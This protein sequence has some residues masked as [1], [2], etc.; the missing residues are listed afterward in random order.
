MAGHVG[1][2]KYHI[3]TADKVHELAEALPERL[4]ASVYPAAGCGCR[5]G[6][7]LALE[8]AH[9]NF[10]RREVPIAQQLKVIAGRRPYLVALKT[11]T[12]Y[13]TVELPESVAVP[14]ARHIELYPP[15]EVEIEIETDPRNPRR[16]KALL[17]FTSARG[18]AM[19]PAT[20]SRIWA[21]SAKAVG[22]PP[23]WATT[24]CGTTSQRC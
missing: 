9:V 17:L 21:A 23:R 6:E 11:K 14:L 24:A 22:M 1:G 15:V 10:L 18:E 13:R 3:P 8:V 2:R 12:S 19:Q 20:W 4:S 16:R 7:T 5:L